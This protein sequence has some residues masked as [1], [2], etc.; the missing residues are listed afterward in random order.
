VLYKRSDISYSAELNIIKLKINVIKL[1]ALLFMSSKIIGKNYLLSFIL[2]NGYINR[3]NPI[4]GFSKRIE[5]G[6]SIYKVGGELSAGGTNRA[7]QV[8]VG[9]SLSGRWGVQEILKF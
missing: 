9:E 2:V 3:L 6:V 5:V 8:Q 4:P 7:S 1:L